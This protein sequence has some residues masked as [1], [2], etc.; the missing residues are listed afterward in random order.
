MLVP[1]GRACTKQRG[2]IDRRQG[3][4]PLL[5]GGPAAMRRVQAPS[6]GCRA[7]GIDHLT[8]VGSFEE[9]GHRGGD[10]RI[11]TIGRGNIGGG[12]AELWRSA[13]HDVTETGR[14]GG[15]AAEADAVLVAVPSGSIADALG[16][17]SG[18]QGK[19][20]IDATNAF[21]GRNEEFPSLA[22]EVKSIV[23]GPTA[24]S[25]NLNL[26]DLYPDIPNQ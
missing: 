7:F 21:S 6:R 24:K 20:A 12:L 17:V 22:H 9:A 25:F 3:L 8:R 19:L 11:V 10:M 13:G 2:R 23:G 4:C 15:D 14:D 5:V 26:A 1:A 18:V 16:K